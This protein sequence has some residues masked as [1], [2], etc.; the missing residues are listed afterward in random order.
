MLFWAG[1]E[2]SEILIPAALKITELEE[3]ADIFCYK[4]SEGNKQ[5]LAIAKLLISSSNIWVLDEIDSA[6]DEANTALLSNLMATKANNGGIIFFSSHR[7]I[8]PHSFK[9][10]V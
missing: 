3:M 7:E 9:I 5:K 2:N 1:F 4:L 8:L 6:L 10:E